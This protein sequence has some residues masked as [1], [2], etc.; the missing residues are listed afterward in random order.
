MTTAHTRPTRRAMIGGLGLVTLASATI[1]NGIP[2]A[3]G[4]DAAIIEAWRHREAAYAH[5]WTLPDNGHD[6]GEQATWR[7]IDRAEEIIR[8]TEARSPEG[9]AI[10]LWVALSHS[11][12]ETEEDKAAVRGDLDWFVANDRGLNWNVRLLVSAL[13]SLQMMGA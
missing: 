6:H 9:M 8:L 4:P 11:V 5:F 13:R 3:N 10:K 7:I 12:G 2:A 1:A